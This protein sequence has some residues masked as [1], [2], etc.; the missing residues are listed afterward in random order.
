M[1]MS[2]YTYSPVPK[3]ALALLVFSL[4]SFAKAAKS[5]IIVID[6]FSTQY[7]KGFL[8]VN[9]FNTSD[10]QTA[11]SSGSIKGNSVLRDTT[12]NLV[13]SASSFATA[14]SFIDVGAL[15]WNNNTG[16]ASDLTIRHEFSAV[17]VL[18][19]F[20][21]EFGSVDL[22][23][24]QIDLGANV[25]ITLVDN[26]DESASFSQ[27]VTSGGA[28]QLTFNYDD[29]LSVNSSLDLTQIKKVTTKLSQDAGQTAVDME[30][31][32]ILFNT[33]EPSSVM[34]FSLAGIG[35]ASRRRRKRS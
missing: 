23:V 15:S 12:L 16:V 22:D 2:T 31:D 24:N 21:S 20:G 5:E 4:A 25:T 18:S 19:P 26:N 17:N 8:Q 11:E 9:S 28:Q 34:L 3:L 1:N 33:P 29:F 30:I 13:S 14:S 27:S 6:N 32:S 10:T 35:L 7:G